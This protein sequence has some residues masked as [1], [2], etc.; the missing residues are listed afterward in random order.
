M[1]EK[2][3]FKTP[4]VW[5]SVKCEATGAHTWRLMA[6]SQTPIPSPLK[7]E[8]VIGMCVDCGKISGGWVSE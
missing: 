1:G 7:H 2:L 3:M 5:A 8:P 6:F 4:G